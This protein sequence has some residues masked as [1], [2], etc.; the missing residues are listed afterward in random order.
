[1]VKNDF[2]ALLLIHPPLSNPTIGIRAGSFR[3]Q[4]NHWKKIMDCSEN[5][6]LMFNG[7]N[8]FKYEMWNIRMK[9][10]L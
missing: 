9:V 8:G 1:M 3:K 10:F 7:Q 4:F 6:V 5:G 2:I